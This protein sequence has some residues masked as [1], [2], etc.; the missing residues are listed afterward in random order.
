MATQADQLAVSKPPQHKEVEDFSDAERTEWLKTGKMPALEELDTKTDSSSEADASAAS[1]PASKEAGGKEPGSGPGKKAR[2]QDENWRALEAD[3]NAEREKREAAEKK[4]QE[5][6]REL[7]EYRTGKRKPEEKKADAGPKLLEMPKRPKMSEF[8]AN[9][10]L[11]SEKYEAALDK[12]EEEKTA[13]T[14]QQVQLR[15]AQQQQEASLAKWT[16]EIKAKYGDKAS[17]LDVKKTV[18]ALAAT[19]QTAP[20]FFMVLNDSEVFTD[21]VYV[22]GTDPKLDELLAEAKDPKT[23]MR[24][25][26]KLIA[27]ENGVKEELAKQSKEPAKKES[28]DKKLTSAGRPPSEAAGAASSPADD[29]SSEAALRRKDL[30]P[31]ERGELYRERKNKEDR[32][33]RRKKVN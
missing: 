24:A 17:G 19:M 29:G 9:G 8:S 27:F 6:E 1:K 14:N 18:D 32:E 5:V 25:V 28:S 16:G 13:Y 12:Y 21:L 4:A 11:D 30:S 23:G 33:K 26:R 15:T 22:L 7:E 20:A 3:R 2:S 31:E 10:T